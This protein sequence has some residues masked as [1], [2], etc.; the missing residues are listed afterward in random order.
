LLWYFKRRFIG[1]PN[2]FNWL[3]NPSFESL[4]GPPNQFLWGQ[5]SAIGVAA[6]GTLAYHFLGAGGM[7]LTQA[8]AGVDT[9]LVQNVTPSAGNYYTVTAWVYINAF[10]GPAL[11]SRGLFILHQDVN[12]GEIH[13]ANS[14]IDASF[15]AGKAYRL[16]TGILVPKESPVSLLQVRLYAPG[17]TVTWDATSLTLMESLS[18]VQT[19]QAT[20]VND[21][22]YHAQG[23][24]RNGNNVP[25]PGPGYPAMYGKSDLNI[26]T[27][28]PATG[29]TR[30]RIYQHA[31]HQNCGEL[32]HEF[33]TLDDGIDYS[34]EVSATERKF[35]TYFPRKGNQIPIAENRLELGRN[36]R[37][38]SINT[39]IES[40][41]TSV[42]VLGGDDGPGREEAGAV[43][44]SYTGGI[45]YEQ[46]YNS[47][48]GTPIDALPAV[49]N[50]QL[51]RTKKPVV[52]PELTTMANST[53]IE[54]VTVGDVIGVYLNYS[55]F[56]LDDSYRIV[57]MEIHPKDDSVTL[58][59]NTL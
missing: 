36:V 3:S 17:G 40:T 55:V 6:Q 25:S 11:E 57:K 39:N 16:Q 14:P 21:I 23:K 18:N 7:S 29:I 12:T 44:T 59:L 34:I 2:R 20:I 52:I 24:D 5:W 10:T 49:A 54:G 13:T 1:Q 22:V 58:T 4:I 41:A 35:T 9:Y 15:E 43:D 53:L 19:E 51:R 38:F 31:D 45:I 50:E 28:C 46:I 32:L 42:T 27:N 37:D 26:I 56:T 8:N 48:P 47:I 30:T 33:V